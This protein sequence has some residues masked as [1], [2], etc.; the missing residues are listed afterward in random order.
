MDSA[1][2][3]FNV[4]VGTELRRSFYDWSWTNK[5]VPFYSFLVRAMAGDWR[6]RSARNVGDVICSVE[7]HLTCSEN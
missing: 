1:I 3:K 2:R 4:C 7:L 6:V 5:L